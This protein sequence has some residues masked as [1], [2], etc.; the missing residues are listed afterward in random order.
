MLCLDSVLGSHK[1]KEMLWMNDLE[2]VNVPQQCEGYHH[3]NKP[4]DIC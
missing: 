3:V 4:G 2:K 1:K